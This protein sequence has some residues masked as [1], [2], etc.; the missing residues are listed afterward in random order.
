MSYATHRYSSSCWSQL[1]KMPIRFRRFKPDR[2]EIWWERSSSKYASI[3][4]DF[5]FDVAVSIWRPWHHFT[6]KSAAIWWVRMQRPP[7]HT[8]ASSW[9]VVYFVFFSHLAAGLLKFTWLAGKQRRSWFVVKI[10][11][12][13]RI[14]GC[15]SA[16]QEKL[17]SDKMINVRNIYR[18]RR[19][20]RVR[21]GGV[22]G[23]RNVIDSV[24]VV[25]KSEQFSFQM[26]KK[27]WTWKLQ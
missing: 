18:R 22:G 27:F 9:S 5:R 21:I 24:R 3:E 26:T 13:Y 7:V 2:D 11:A 17:T 16:K 4:S 23:R 1:F 12:V 15:F 20:S 25:C 19:T 14:Y 8:S 6:Q 10:V